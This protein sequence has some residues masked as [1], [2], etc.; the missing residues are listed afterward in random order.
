MRRFDVVRR[1]PGARLVRSIPCSSPLA[2]CASL[3]AAASSLL[4]AC[5]PG[6]EESER[7]TATATLPFG[8]AVL[9]EERGQYRPWERTPDDLPSLAGLA[10]GPSALY[11]VRGPSIASLA[12]DAV[13]AP[14]ALVPRWLG[15]RA[16][17]LSVVDDRIVWLADR[18]YAMALASGDA[19]PLA[20]TPT[21]RIAV[22]GSDVYL[23][24]HDAT[25]L[26]SSRGGAPVELAR[27]DGTF[28]AARALLAQDRDAI[29]VTTFSVFET[30][31]IYRVAKRDGA[32][33]VLDATANGSDCV[34]LV[35]AGE[36]VYAACGRAD[37]RGDELRRYPIGGGARE[38][39]APFIGVEL[40]SASPIFVEDRFVYGS[41]GVFGGA[42]TQ[43]IVRV[44]LTTGASEVLATPRAGSRL[45]AWTHDADY[46]YLA[47]SE[48]TCLEHQGP[49]KGGM[50]GGEACSLVDCTNRIERVG[51]P[52]R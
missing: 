12:K 44:D 52:E 47:E 25:I 48:C 32:V 21:H 11:V 50:P 15:D 6:T 26:R 27:L 29:Y 2:L 35:P 16:E 49:N 37:R 20:E 14:G 30:S 18:P 28:H 51:R 8:G 45:E 19:Q 46:F 31:G 38:I 43:E 42:R 9:F 7:A 33:T 36:W 4:L 3:V 17:A 5:A 1:L 23:A 24:T 10:A 40:G 34:W 22:D 39:V 13:T 41:T